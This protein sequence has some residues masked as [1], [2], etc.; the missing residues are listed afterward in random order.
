MIKRLYRVFAHA[1]YNHLEIF[2]DIENDSFL[3]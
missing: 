2:K 1:Y 3:Y